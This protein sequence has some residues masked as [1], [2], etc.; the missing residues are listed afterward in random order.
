MFG[1]CIKVFTF[2]Q[3]SCILKLHETLGISEKAGI[4]GE[5][6]IGCDGCGKT[7]LQDRCI[8]G[9]LYAIIKT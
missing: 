4:C 9:E 7:V 3:L 1:F 6:R 2:L 5:E 8:K